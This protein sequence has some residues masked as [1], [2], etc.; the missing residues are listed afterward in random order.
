MVLNLQ[1]KDWE[2]WKCTQKLRGKKFKCEMRWI[3]TEL[4]WHMEQKDFV[5]ESRIMAFYE[6]QKLFL[7]QK[8]NFKWMRVHEMFIK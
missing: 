3:A 1:Q 8:S 4:I 6:I 2:W 7:K 5:D